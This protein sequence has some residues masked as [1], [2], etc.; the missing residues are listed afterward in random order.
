LIHCAVEFVKSGDRALSMRKE[1]GAP[2]WERQVLQ[3]RI[4]MMALVGKR[5]P[6]IRLIASMSSP[7]RLIYV[8]ESG[9]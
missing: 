9:A 3:R 6:N 5:E 8:H 4:F 1:L 7:S 2:S